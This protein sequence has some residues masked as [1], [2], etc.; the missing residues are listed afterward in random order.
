MEISLP[1]ISISD[2]DNTWEILLWYTDLIYTYTLIN[3]YYNGD[4]DTFS[5]IVNSNTIMYVQQ[6]WTQQKM[7]KYFQAFLLHSF[8]YVSLGKFR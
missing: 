3:K 7:V 1:K 4:K 5:T 8:V 6:N 2:V